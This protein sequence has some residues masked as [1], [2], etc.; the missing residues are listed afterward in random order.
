MYCCLHFI[1]LLQLYNTAVDMVVTKSFPHSTCTSSTPA[2]KMHSEQVLEMLVHGVPTSLARNALYLRVLH[3][4]CAKKCPSL[5]RNAL[6]PRVLHNS[7]VITVSKKCQL[8]TTQIRAKS[9]A[10]A[11]I[12]LVRL[13]FRL[14]K[15]AF[16]CCLEKSC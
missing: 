5:A 8:C 13:R 10:C 3:N 2:L 7:C 11:D 1:H 4:S 12:Y 14:L 15:M 16:F 6:Y 9:Y